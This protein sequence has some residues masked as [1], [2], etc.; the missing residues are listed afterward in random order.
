MYHE[1]VEKSSRFSER[2]SRDREWRFFFSRSRY[3]AFCADS[4]SLSVSFRVIAVVRK[5]SRSFCQKC[6]WQVTPKHAYTL[7]Q[8]NRSG[9]TA[10]VQ[11]YCWNLYGN[12]LTHNLSGNIRP[13]SSQLAEPL[14]TDPGIK[15]GISVH[16]LISTSKREEKEKSAGGK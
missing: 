11:S 1:Q 13:Q 4:Y 10:A 15:R 16:E 12:E 14:W 5:R 3:L 7:D 8:T 9:L 6:S 2:R